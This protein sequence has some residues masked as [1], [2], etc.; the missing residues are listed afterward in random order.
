MKYIKQYE[1]M[2]PYGNDK[3]EYYWEVPIEM[4]NLKIALNKI[5]V[6]SNDIYGFIKDLEGF[7]DTNPYDSYVI[8]MSDSRK[9]DWDWTKLHS[10]GASFFP[11]DA[12]FMGRVDAEKWEIDKEQYNL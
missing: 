1:S 9:R 7:N 8:F 4:P 11:N 3:Y 12:T 2:T 5:G 10:V 6:P